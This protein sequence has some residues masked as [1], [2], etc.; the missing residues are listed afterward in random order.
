MRSRNLSWRFEK[1]CCNSCMLLRD[2]GQLSRL[3][4]ELLLLPFGLAETRG[5]QKVV[6]CFSSYVKWLSEFPVPSDL[7]DLPAFTK[8]LKQILQVRKTAGMVGDE[9]SGYIIDLTY[10][11]YIDVTLSLS[12]ICKL[13]IPNPSQLLFTCCLFNLLILVSY[14][15]FLFLI[16]FPNCFQISLC[17]GS[18]TFRKS[19]RP[20]PVCSQSAGI[21]MALLGAEP[22]LSCSLHVE[23]KYIHIEKDNI[24]IYII[25]IFKRM[26]KK[27]LNL[28]LKTWKVKNLDHLISIWLFDWV[29]QFVL[30]LGTGIWVTFWRS[31]TDWSTCPSESLALQHWF[32][33]RINKQEICLRL[34]NSN[35]ICWLFP[36]Y[37]V[38][39]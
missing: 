6:E 14:S 30:C 25:Y 8:L 12:G 32:K 21:P 19:C 38:W 35:E 17:W 34:F 31:R 28:F 9:N 11:K 24:Y 7:S 5:I 16:H 23:S 36:L 26:Y 10:R 13:H 22:L 15:S 29:G 4:K 20:F 3:C 1:N 18:V 39:F 37:F 33:S 27:D 2:F